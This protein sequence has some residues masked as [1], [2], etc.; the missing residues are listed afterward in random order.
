MRCVYLQGSP[1]AMGEMFGEGFRAEIQELAG[2]RMA[3]ALTQARIYGGRDVEQG[4]V[5]GVAAV[6]LEAS[7]AHHPDGHAELLGIA[8]GAELSPEATMALGGL[9]DLRDALA[10]GGPLEAFGGCTGFLV[11]AGQMSQG[12]LRFGQTWD[13][14]T[15]NQPFVV[16]VH[17]Q[18]KVGPATWCVT[19][20]GC[21]SL[22]G[23]NEH[24]LAVGTTNLR[25]R[26]ARAGVPY[27]NLIHRALTEHR[28]T[29]A[30]HSIET[31]HRAGAHSYFL[32]DA[33]G[34]AAIVECT[35]T[36]SDVRCLGLS[37]QVQTNHCQ[38]PRHAALE[39]DTPRAS[40]EARLARMRALLAGGESFDDASLRGFLADRQ[41]GTLAINRDDFD[42]ISTNAAMLA[43]PAEGRL[44]VCHGAPDRGHWF[45]FGP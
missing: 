45:P 6:C 8:R 36:R 19:T 14:G 23:I 31:A 12:G 3:N 22:M 13:L 41:D 11:P 20:V 27:L 7:A 40:S 9:T 1:A 29:D 5:W 38:V 34:E 33:R 10:W 28:A 43:A 35:A 21:L 26:D 24:G 39:G 4:A 25:T 42:G 2:L 16:A 30:I 37:S 18:P 17:R 32:A 15:D 44:E